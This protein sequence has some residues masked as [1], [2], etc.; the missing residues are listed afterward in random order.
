MRRQK[1]VIREISYKNLTKFNTDAV[2]SVIILMMFAAYI[3]RHM[4]IHD[5]I[6]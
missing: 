4:E 2:F 1:L 3:Y 6:I 5:K